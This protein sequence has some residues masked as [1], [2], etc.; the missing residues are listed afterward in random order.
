MR[1]WGVKGNKETTKK[2]NNGT[3]RFG[4][5]LFR[6]LW[7]TAEAQTKEVLPILQFP[8]QLIS[9]ILITTAVVNETSF[10][11]GHEQ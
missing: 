11:E 10:S 3:V 9:A 4:K 8:F 5:Q 7:A 1:E 2:Y 6:S